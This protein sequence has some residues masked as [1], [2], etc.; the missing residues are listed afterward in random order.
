VDI[1]IPRFTLPLHALHDVGPSWTLPPTLWG[2]G[3]SNP[4]FTSGDPEI[5]FKTRSSTYLLKRKSIR[6][7]AIMQIFRAGH[8]DSFRENG[9]WNFWAN[10][11][12][13]SS[14]PSS[15]PWRK[16]FR[17]IYRPLRTFLKRRWNFAEI[18]FRFRVIAIW[19]FRFCH[20]LWGSITQRGYSAHAWFFTDTHM[21]WC[22]LIPA[23][24][25]K[26]GLILIELFKVK[27][28]KQRPYVTHCR[29][30]SS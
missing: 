2:S 22:S 4:K 8:L 12:F 17:D 18:Y 11:H 30:R 27:L 10:T 7:S 13:S 6:P 26:I 23:S 1:V 25:T 20:F 9:V 24:L 19:I 29:H 28:C 3:P 16:I 15:A 5:F 14:T 21:L